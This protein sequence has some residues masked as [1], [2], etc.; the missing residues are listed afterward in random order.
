MSIKLEDDKYCFVCGEKNPYGLKLTFDL[1][2]RT[3]KTKFKSEKV[4]QGYKNI[5]HGGIIGIVLDEMLVNLPWKLGIEAVTAE[6]TI[7]LKKPVYIGE[8]LE[9]T[10]N[11]LKEQGRLLLVEACARDIKGEIVATASGKC[12]KI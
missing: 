8:E 2:G 3:L 7:R 1:E 6:Y 11:I 4:H 9:F 12:M 5:V 10:S